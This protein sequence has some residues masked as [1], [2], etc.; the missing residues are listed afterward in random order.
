M[1]GIIDEQG[2]RLNVGIILVGAEGR[3]FWGRRIGN[4]DAWQFPQGGVMPGETPEQALY[5]ELEE[6][7]GLTQCDVEVLA[8]TEGWLSYRL[9]RRFLRRRDDTRGPQCIGQRQKW[10][11]LRLVSDEQR[12]DL[13]RSDTPE[14]ESWRWVSYWYPIRK[15]VHFKRGVYARA[16]KE[17]APIMRREAYLRQS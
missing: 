5:R 8:C 3:V 16:L 6:E 12:I 9:P 7:V 10:F 17:L 1:T 11:L 4:R 14:F 2:F 13:A 15:V